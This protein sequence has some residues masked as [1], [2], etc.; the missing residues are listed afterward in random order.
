[1]LGSSF[2]INRMNAWASS[3][4]YSGLSPHANSAH[5]SF[6]IYFDRK[7]DW[8]RGDSPRQLISNFTFF[9]VNRYLAS[10][11]AIK[12]D[13]M[14]VCL[15]TFFI[16]RRENE[17]KLMVVSLP[18]LS[19]VLCPRGI[20]PLSWAQRSA[21]G[22]L[23]PLLYHFK[24]NNHR[25]IHPHGWRAGG[26][27]PPASVCQPRASGLTLGVTVHHLRWSV[28]VVLSWPVTSLIKLLMAW[29]AGGNNRRGTRCGDSFFRV[30]G[31][32]TG[33]ALSHTILL[34][35]SIRLR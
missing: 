28:R 17:V 22:C 3:G 2:Q 29:S 21:W 30:W 34:N 12:Y 18:P 27:P 19:P 23:W 6:A 16:S 11:N 8:Y 9:F 13:L 32:I 33:Q 1:M 10:M 4:F 24:G 26:G 14:Y 31:T 5:Q 35:S 25:S 7:T 20:Q 15:G